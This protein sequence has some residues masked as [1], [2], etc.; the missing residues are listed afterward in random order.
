MLES[1]RVN[2]TEQPAEN[3]EAVNASED[4]TDQDDDLL[5]PNQRLVWY[6]LILAVFSSIAFVRLI[7][8]T[9]STDGGESADTELLAAIFIMNVAIM[10]FAGAVGGSLY[11]VRGLIKHSGDNDFNPHYNLTYYLAPF[12]GGISG[13]IVFVLL[14]G[15]ALTLSLTP[16]NENVSP[17]WT[18]LIGRMPYIAFALLA[19]YSSREFMLKA[20]DVAVTLFTVREE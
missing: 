14:L 19:G 8:L 9:P 17:G 6:T 20:K 13:V 11:N 3:A 12:A 18:T 15:G 2:S 5:Q 10:F 4:G 16:V 7:M 1:E